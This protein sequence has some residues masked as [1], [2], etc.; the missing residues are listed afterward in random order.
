MELRA[1]E[2]TY[3][4]SSRPWKSGNPEGIS[5]ECGKGGKP[6]FW[7]SMLSILCHFHGLS[8]ARQCRISHYANECIGDNSIIDDHSKVASIIVWVSFLISGRNEYRIW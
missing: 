2:K 1:H 3:T 8:F 7:L 4:Q 6:A 5:K